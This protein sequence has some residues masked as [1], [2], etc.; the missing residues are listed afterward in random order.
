[1]DYLNQNAKYWAGTYNA[2]NVENFI[3]RMYGRILRHDYGMDGSKGERVFDFGMGQGGR[4]TSSTSWVSTFSGWTSLRRMWKS[5]G[6][7]CRSVRVS[8]A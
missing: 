5:P 8:S 2:P 3:F 4:F 1:M 7:R 6:M